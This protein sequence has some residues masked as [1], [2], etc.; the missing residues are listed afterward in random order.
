MRPLIGLLLMAGCTP[1]VD[2]D[3]GLFGTQ[4]GASPLEPGQFEGEMDADVVYEGSLGGPYEGQCLGGASFYID[5]DGTIDGTG[6]CTLEALTMGFFIQGSQDGTEIEG[7]LI[8]ES[9][10]ES[11]TTPF[12]GERDGNTVELRYD[13]THVNDGESLLIRGTIIAVRTDI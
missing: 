9:Q 5:E 4:D 1:Q 12:E 2:N 13:K 6:D 8:A 7:G 11:V 3:T 10:G